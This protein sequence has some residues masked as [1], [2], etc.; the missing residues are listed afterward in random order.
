MTTSKFI[1]ILKKTRRN[2]PNILGV[3]SMHT[4]LH[5]LLCIYIYIYVC[6]ILVETLFIVEFCLDENSCGSCSF[7]SEGQASVGGTIREEF[8][9]RCPFGINLQGLPEKLT[10]S[11]K[12]E[13]EQGRGGCSG[14]NRGEDLASGLVQRIW[15]RSE[16]YTLWTR[17]V[18]EVIQT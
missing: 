6:V 15:Y 14:V 12:P 10:S 5:T 7:S 3:Q 11:E 13:E 1:I 8:K 18:L 17:K 16:D 9:S 4:Y 2:P